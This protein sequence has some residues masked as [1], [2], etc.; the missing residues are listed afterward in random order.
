MRQEV[1][2]ADKKIT[3]IGTAHISQASIDEV[4]EVIREIKPDTVCVELCQARYESIQN[5]DHWKKMDIV[6][7]VKEGK[8]PLLMGNLVLS[9]FQKKMGDQLGIKPGAEMVAAIK[10]TEEVQARTVLADREVSITLKRAWGNLS[11]WGKIKLLG[12]IFG[13]L[14]ES[15]D[16]TE[17]D[18][19][20]LKQGDL[21]T[22]AIET[23]AKEMPGIK[24]A[25]IDERDRYLATKISSA[26]GKEI[27]AVVGAGH[28]PGIIKYLGEPFDLEKLEQLP[29]KGKLGTILKWTLPT[30]VLGIII[31]GFLR[32]DTSVSLE[33][34]KRWVL[35]NGVLA[36]LGA[37]I[38]GGHILT[39]VMAFVAAPITS[40]NPTI[41]AGWVAGLT[42]A[43]IRKPKVEDFESLAQ[44]ITSLKGFRRNEITRILL[45]VVMSNVG[46]G[47]GTL[48]GVPLVASL[49]R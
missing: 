19:E 41:A 21:L 8:A 3:L 45:V 6:K 17:D 24:T 9:A 40:L 5:K 16:I 33:M 4:E 29:P 13:S 15:H 22:E 36:A 1:T 26:E 46:S 7:V 18:V 25:L 48:I 30:I 23:M 20:K 47:I 12:Q 35:I 44:D 32:I 28:L 42:E 27:V 2:I 38:A 49:L 37:L 43:W 31:Y 14:F 34:I 39:V 11:F 10:V